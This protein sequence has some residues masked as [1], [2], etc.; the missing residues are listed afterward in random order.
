ML[1]K[2][3][4]TAQININVHNNTENKKFCDNGKYEA[5]NNTQDINPTTTQKIYLLTTTQQM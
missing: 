5:H 4:T 1:D 2:T 3:P